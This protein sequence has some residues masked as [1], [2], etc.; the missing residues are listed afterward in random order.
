[1]LFDKKLDKI[2]NS[3]QIKDILDKSN[4]SGHE[5][6]IIMCYI[7]DLEDKLKYVKEKIDNSSLYDLDGKYIYANEILDIIDKEQ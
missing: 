6:K 2:E 1:M 5:E 7:Y 3:L 4:V